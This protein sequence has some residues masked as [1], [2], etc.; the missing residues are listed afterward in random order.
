MPPVRRVWAGYVNLVR[1]NAL[2]L[3]QDLN[4]VLVIGAGVAEDVGEHDHIF[5]LAQRREFFGKEC[6]RANILQADGIQHSG[7]GLIQARRR[8]SGHRFLGETFDHQSAKP[9]EMHDV[10]EFDAIT[11]GAGSGDDRI[12]QL[13][14][15]E[16]DAQVRIADGRHCVPPAGRGGWCGGR[17][18]RMVSRNDAAAAAPR[19]AL[20]PWLAPAH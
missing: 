13:D 15:R 10:F 3:I 4:R 20:F 2:A 7:S 11:E 14:A 16:A 17:R 8:I 18:G 19:S 12:L 5:L 9:V 1:R 6:G